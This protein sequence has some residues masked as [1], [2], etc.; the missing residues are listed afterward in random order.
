MPCICD[1]YIFTYFE[2]GYNAFWKKSF[3]MSKMSSKFIILDF[4]KYSIVIRCLL[5]CPSYNKNKDN[6]YHSI[7]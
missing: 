4:K 3:K 6:K 7:K 5:S 1:K 2:Y